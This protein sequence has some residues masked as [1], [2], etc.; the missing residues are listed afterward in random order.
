MAKKTRKSPSTATAAG[1]TATDYVLDR[2][3]ARRDAKKLGLNKA[4][5]PNS[6]KEV[7]S[8]LTQAGF[9]AYIVGGGVR[10]ALL[11]LKPKDFDAVT[12][13][14][15]NQ[16]K[17]VFGKRCRIIGRRFQLCHVYSGRD[18]I[19]VATFRA[20]P[21]DNNHLTEDGM[22]MRDNVWGDIYQDVVRR[23]FSINA[24]YYQPFD[25]IVYDFCGGLNDI[26]NRTIRLLGDTQK[27][28]EEDPV[29]LLRALRFK[30]KLQFDFDNA[31][32]QQFNAQNWALLAQVSPHRL[33]DETQKMFT[34]GYLVPMLPLLFDYGAFS[35]LLFCPPTTVTPLLNQVTINTDR[36]IGSGKSINP[37]FFYATILWENYLY[38]LDK[39]KK[40]TPFSDAQNQAA[41][42]VLDKQRQH[43]TMPKF[44]EQ[45]IKDI[46]LMQ[47]RLAQPRKKN[48]QKLFENP[49]F[50]AAYDFLMMREQVEAKNQALAKQHGAA[51]TLD[52]ESTNGMGHWWA[53]FQTLG[54][55]QQ[56]QAIDE[57][58]LESVRLRFANIV[59]QTSFED[60]S[61]A[62]QTS[63]TVHDNEADMGSD[64]SHGK[65]RR[66]RRRLPFAAS[67]QIEHELV[68][69]A[70]LSTKAHKLTQQQQL[71]KAQLQ[72]LSLA[73]HTN[74]APAKS[75]IVAPITAPQNNDH[76]YQS[77]SSALT[78]AET[79]ARPN[80]SHQSNSH[81]NNSNPNN[82]HPN[83][84]NLGRSRKRD[85]AYLS[86]AIVPAKRARRT[87]SSNWSI[88][89]QR[90]Q[91]D[92]ATSASDLSAVTPPDTN[93]STDTGT[94]TVKHSAPNESMIDN[95]VV[96]PKPKRAPR[97]RK[98]AVTDSKAPAEA[99]T[100]D[101]AP[102]KRTRKRA[103]KIDG[104]QP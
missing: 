34:G 86:A 71:E 59:N 21:K 20:P 52:N 96:Q 69:D 87:P 31:L 7:I 67:H 35:Q 53:W 88:L 89:E 27:R 18:M 66:E 29:R 2:Q 54:A 23:D 76:P 104:H 74:S 17:E 3:S 12:N 82:S 43:T 16:I 58:D 28:V 8:T 5:L 56:Q 78:Y 48:L 101:E 65:H 4:D 103:V 9:E 49:R 102:A 63:D 61:V 14:T 60:D 41:N 50:R 83:N 92:I 11:G 30:A 95:G 39:F 72:Q 98:K 6:I 25:D 37:A 40:N 26:E 100:K 22:I 38:L 99:V 32:N 93:I 73:S 79:N 81:P 94:G 70:A 57:F 77:T 80:N 10:D 75:L 42:K 90:Q 45:F 24:L 68:Q 19:E 36:R 84:S 85:K 97:T 47:P 51:I 91:A 64:F 44:A 55:K 62:Y 13:A 1:N 46:W 15:P 33:Y